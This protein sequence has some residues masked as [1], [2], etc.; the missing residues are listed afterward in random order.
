MKSNKKSQNKKEKNIPRRLFD[1]ERILKT[2]IA[3]ID[4]KSKNSNDRIESQ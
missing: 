4:I 2:E 3:D 1:R